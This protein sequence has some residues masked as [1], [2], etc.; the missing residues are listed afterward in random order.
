[1]GRIIEQNTSSN[2][3][4]G[5]MV[6]ISGTLL[7][8]L[9]IANAAIVLIKEGSVSAARS[10]TTSAASVGPGMYRIGLDATDTNTLGTLTVYVSASAALQYAVDIEVWQS[11]TFK[12]FYGSAVL[13]QLELLEHKGARHRAAP[14]VPGRAGFA[15]RAHCDGRREIRIQLG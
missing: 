4:I 10:N 14:I 12:L 11:T 9:T 3:V 2:V 6:N 8:A 5:P 15:K 13:H 7:S 1:M